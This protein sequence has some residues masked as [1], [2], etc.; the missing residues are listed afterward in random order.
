[1]NHCLLTAAHALAEELT[2]HGSADPRAR[3]KARSARADQRAVLKVLRKRA[4]YA[5]LPA[6]DHLIG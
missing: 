4:G 2:R 6:S 5:G 1:M 3:N